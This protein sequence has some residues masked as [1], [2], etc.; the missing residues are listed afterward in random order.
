MHNLN[1]LRWRAPGGARLF[2]Y[3]AFVAGILVITAGPLA[4]SPAAAASRP[5]DVA[6]TTSATPQALFGLPPIGITANWHLYT[7]PGGLYFSDR[8]GTITV[9]GKGFTP[10]GTVQVSLDTPS[11]VFEQT[12]TAAEPSFVCGARYC[13]PNPGGYFTVT[14]P[15][16]ACGNAPPDVISSPDSF[17][18]A[19]DQQTGTDGYADLATPCPQLHLTGL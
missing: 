18:L 8:T 14:E 17:I 6:A 7:P 3:G 10:G 12:V 5:A 16:I 11:G 2:R 1:H 13:Y 9:Y 19:T 4:A 15:D